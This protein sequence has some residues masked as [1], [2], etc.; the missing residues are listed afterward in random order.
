MNEERI[1]LQAKKS[2]SKNPTHIILM[3]NIKKS[4]GMR[5]GAEKPN[6]VAKLDIFLDDT[7][8]NLILDN[9]KESGTVKRTRGISMFAVTEGIEIKEGDYFE[10]NGYKY[11][12]TYPGMIIKDVYNSDLEVIKNG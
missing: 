4:N 7:K 11:I 6:K 3:R 12:V 8:H 1:K 2:I 9:V 10:A 5:G